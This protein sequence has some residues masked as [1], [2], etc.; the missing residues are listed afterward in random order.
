[1]ALLHM[2]FYLL[3]GNSGLAWRCPYGDNRG[4][5]EK[6]ESVHLDF[7]IVLLANKS[8]SQTQ[9]QEVEYYSCSQ[10]T[11]MAKLPL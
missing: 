6:V 4:A 11:G 5:R 9:G 8:H 10:L 3:P 1:M 2:F 7:C